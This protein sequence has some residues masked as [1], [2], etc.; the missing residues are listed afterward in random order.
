MEAPGVSNGNEGCCCQ[1][2]NP[3]A[4]SNKPAVADVIT[5][6]IVKGNSSSNVDEDEDDE[7]SRMVV[8][9]FACFEA[10]LWRSLCHYNCLQAAKKT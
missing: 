9:N 10:K 7:D 5:Q 8:H 3:V 1:R 4:A 6:I 2:Q